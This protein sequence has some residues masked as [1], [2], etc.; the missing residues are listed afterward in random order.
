ME[1]EIGSFFDRDM[2]DNWFQEKLCLLKKLLII[3]N[4]F[5]VIKYD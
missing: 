5:S 2:F 4:L 1:I 3:E